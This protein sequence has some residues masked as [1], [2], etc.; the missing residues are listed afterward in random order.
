MAALLARRETDGLSLRALSEESGIPFGTLS[1][2]SWRL[3]QG[4]GARTPAEGGFVEVVAT[5]GGVREAVVVRVG[6]DVE[7]EVP[8][9]TDVTWLRDLAVALRA[10]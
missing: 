9:G 5:G 10:C 2:W 6:R 3:R 8:P 1:W 4:P 7:I